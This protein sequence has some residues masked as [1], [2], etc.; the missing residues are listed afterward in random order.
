MLLAGNL[1]SFC[2]LFVDSFTESL[3]REKEKIIQGNVLLQT[4]IKPK[5]NFKKASESKIEFLDKLQYE[6]VL[7]ST[8]IQE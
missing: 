6:G 3:Y 5:P 8:K 1:A 2:S 4:K 7:R